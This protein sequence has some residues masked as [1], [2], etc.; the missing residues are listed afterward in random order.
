MN[1]NKKLAV[2]SGYDLGLNADISTFSFLFIYVFTKNWKSLEV[3]FEFF[4]EIFSFKTSKS[5]TNWDA[6]LPCQQKG[7]L[8]N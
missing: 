1:A 4:W 8:E 7:Y 5:R 3:S 6:Q 2:I